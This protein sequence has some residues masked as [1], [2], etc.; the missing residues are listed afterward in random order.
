MYFD[1]FNANKSICFFHPDSPLKLWNTNWDSV[2]VCVDEPLTRCSVSLLGLFHYFWLWIILAALRWRRLNRILLLHFL[3]LWSLCFIRLIFCYSSLSRMFTRSSRWNI[4]GSAGVFLSPSSSTRL[5]H[6]AWLSVSL[7]VSS[8][9]ISLSIWL[10]AC[11]SLCLSVSI[12]FK[13]ALL[14]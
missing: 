14:A 10:T 3:C 4:T 6:C 8:L 5:C 7:P 9:S 13:S 12:Q 2:W 1:Q 11:L